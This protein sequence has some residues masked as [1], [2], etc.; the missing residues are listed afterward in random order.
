MMGLHSGDP[1]KWKAK[2][3]LAAILEISMT[4]FLP[5]RRSFFS[6][7]FFSFSLRRS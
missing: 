6:T 1:K 5:Q 7:P 3:T 2:D 4:R